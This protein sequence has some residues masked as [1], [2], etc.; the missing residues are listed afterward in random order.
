M[1]ETLSCRYGMYITGVVISVTSQYDNPDPSILSPL[2]CLFSLFLVLS[3]VISIS[4]LSLSHVHSNN[5]SYLFLN[6]LCSMCLLHVHLG[7][8]P[9]A[10]S[11]WEQFTVEQ[12]INLVQYDCIIGLFLYYGKVVFTSYPH[13]FQAIVCEKLP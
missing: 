8:R 6:L 13:I 9:R 4:P 11:K 5:I 10:K 2:L 12:I 3:L 1:Y 7:Y